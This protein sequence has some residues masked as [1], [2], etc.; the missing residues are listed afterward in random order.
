MD[1]LDCHNRPAHQL[2]DTV[3]RAVDRALVQGDVSRSLPFARRELVAALSESYA[4]AGTAAQQIAARL[5]QA[6]G[7]HPEGARAIQAAQR[8]YSQNVFPRMNVTW[9]TYKNQLYHP[10]QSGCFRCHDDE[11]KATTDPEKVV[12]QDCELCH[13]EKEAP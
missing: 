12:R 13:L 2:S 8:L 5:Q 10:D 1:C 6:F 4:D 11:H 3:E 7:S 9:G